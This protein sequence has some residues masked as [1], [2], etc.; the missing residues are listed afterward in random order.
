MMAALDLASVVLTA[1]VTPAP[2][3]GGRLSVPLEANGRNCRPRR[4]MGTLA[5]PA[6][7]FQAGWPRVS[8]LRGHFF[9]AVAL[10]A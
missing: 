9:L 1:P 2:A 4:R 10:A 3:G 8:I 6:F 5:R 7:C